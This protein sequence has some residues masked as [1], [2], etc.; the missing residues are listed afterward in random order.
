MSGKRPDWFSPWRQVRPLGQLP[1][2]QCH[3]AL[4]ECPRLRC[5]SYRHCPWR[6]DWRPCRSYRQSPW[7]GWW[8]PCR[9]YRQSPGRLHNLHIPPGRRLLVW[10]GQA[11]GP[12]WHL[13]PRPPGRR[14]GRRLRGL[15]CWSRRSL[16]TG[17]L[18]SVDDR[19]GDCTHGG[20]APVKPA[21]PRLQH[22]IW[23]CQEVIKW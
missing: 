11:G 9:S 23:K 13:L 18:K 20:Q 1:A 14:R 6:G 10:T 17:V 2:P 8:T 21:P 7:R 3:G 5:W 15:T 12:D 4:V 22:I 19:D 16:A